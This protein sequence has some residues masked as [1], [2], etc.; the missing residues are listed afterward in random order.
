MRKL[1]LLSVAF[2][3][4]AV[5]F[6][7]CDKTHLT[8][9]APE[10]N[11]ETV[12]AAGEAVPSEAALFRSEGGK[13]VLPFWAMVGNA[14]TD[15]SSNFL[16]TLDNQPLLFRTNGAEAM[17]LTSTGRLGIGTTNPAALLHLRS[18]GGTLYE[19]LVQ[20]T[21]PG[22]ASII[23]LSNSVRNWKL[24]SD[25]SPDVFQIESDPGNVPRLAI[26]S[27][28]SVGIG[29]NNPQATLHVRRGAQ[30][31]E[32]MLEE[33]NVGAA[34]TIEMKNSSR[35]W[36]LFADADP[37]YLQIA[38]AGPGGVITILG[39]SG[40]FGIGT[41]SPQSKLHVS[42]GDIRVTGG[43]F[44]DDGTTLNV[45]DYVFEEPYT[46]MSLAD[47]REFIRQEGHLP[48]VPSADDVRRDGLN[49]SQFQMKLLEKVEELTLY[50]LV[51]DEQI[52]ALSTLVAVL[53]NRPTAE[54]Q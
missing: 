22:S 36:T 3:L 16:G 54:V 34:V 53:E 40:Y 5:G 46:L 18:Q 20:E 33:P 45:P 43:S 47:L 37:D 52:Q 30:F 24:V 49:L 8:E 12:A 11:A 27:N 13:A 41:S 48:N 6:Y 2:A 23:N 35:T 26:R 17:R 39:G 25:A 21:N 9:P 29:T 38:G 32:L 44:I 4:V 14:N 19:L 10:S 28:G 1:A 7:G 15:P 51:Q 50:A 42:G 31:N